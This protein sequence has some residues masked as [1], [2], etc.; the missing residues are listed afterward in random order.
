[1]S[2]Q[3]VNP[4]P[5][6]QTSARFHYQHTVRAVFVLL[7]A[8]IGVSVVAI[9]ALSPL[10]RYYLGRYFWA[11]A[12][13]QNSTS[14][15]FAEVLSRG[16]VVFAL[17]TDVAELNGR[18][19]LSQAAVR[20]QR[21]PLSFTRRTVP[22]G[23]FV[24]L[25]QQYV[26]NGR[27]AV[28]I[29]A[30]VAT[31]AIPAALVLVVAGYYLDWRSNQKR[32]VGVIRRGPRLMDREEFNRALG[33]DGVGFQVTGR[34]S[35]REFLV[36]PRWRRGMIRIPGHVETSHVLVVG[37]TG[38][39]K[40]QLL[41]QFMAEIQARDE[42]A[43]LY[44]PD[45]E[46]VSE[47]YDPRR[48]DVV[49]NPLDK[50][51]PYWRP[52]QELAANDEALTL[53]AS[54]FPDPAR[55]DEKNTFFVRAPRQILARLFEYDP[56]PQELVSWLASK[57][58]ID[59]RINGTE[60][61][62]ML[63]RA[64]GPQ[65]AG[66]LASL[67]MALNAFR[68]L[69]TREECEREW[70]AREWAAARRGW[71]FLTSR[72]I[73]RDIQRPLISMWLDTV[74]LRLMT[75]RPDAPIPRPV[76]LIIDELASLNKLPTL[77]SALT[78]ARKYQI[79]TVLGYQQ[80]SQLQELYGKEGAETIT[81]NPATKIFF[82][83]GDA[84]TAKEVSQSLG[85]QEIARERIH[86]TQTGGFQRR[87]SASY[88]IEVKTERA[89]TDSQIEGL[90]N[91]NGYIRIYDCIAPFTLRYLPR[92]ARV[93]TF[94]SRDPLGFAPI[95]A[96]EPYEMRGDY[97]PTPTPS[98]ETMRAAVE[99]KL[100]S[101][102]SGDTEGQILFVPPSE[103]RMARE[104]AGQTRRS[105][106]VRGPALDGSTPQKRGDLSA[107]ETEHHSKTPLGADDHG[108]AAVD[109]LAIE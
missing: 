5:L 76:W 11:S 49:L 48:G 70:S 63:S 109:G 39:G 107:A 59:K 60:M 38:T 105:I 62:E 16:R 89:V 6:T 69:P 106:S 34:P 2:E 20:H 81:G 50:R 95:A 1:M 44:D 64:A 26:Y 86:Y 104:R 12:G 13:L 71:I 88:S 47:F 100:H 99:E 19:V 28:E 72:E 35:L 87:H 41:V 17:P 94:Q 79:K 46:F 67:S 73:T 40:S 25:L 53:A 22:S 32:R 51:C 97:S 18:L 37:A 75:K 15:A 21:G 92:V 43:V 10:Q 14:A 93:A 57:D 52:A 101:P 84:A 96:P 8:V 27:S 56:T 98:S 65:R 29:V 61:A 68:L 58:E 90:R 9:N 4:T 45:G 66:I 103:V 78:R 31:V 82:R 85:E 42:T 23:Y 74:L 55:A 36:A 83:T 30:P 7:V 24:E 54:L 108:L 102:L 33:S 3:N 77:Q 80:Q 91:L